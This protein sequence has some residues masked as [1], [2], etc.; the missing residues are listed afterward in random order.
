MLLNQPRKRR[1]RKKSA[2]LSICDF[3]SSLLLGLLCSP[4]S[5]SYFHTHKHTHK[6]APSRNNQTHLPAVLFL[7]LMIIAHFYDAYIYFCRLASRVPEPSLENF[8]IVLLLK[9]L[10]I[11]HLAELHIFSCTSEKKLPAPYV[12]LEKYWL[13][14]LKSL[15][16]TA[17]WRAVK[18][19]LVLTWKIFI[20]VQEMKKHQRKQLKYFGVSIPI[21]VAFCSF[22]ASMV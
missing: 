4:W 15:K 5:R 6:L 19:R 8:Q 22:V 13:V 2:H 20:R 17:S 14:N 10:K 11:V 9:E 12:Q 21:I 7:F 16:K 18:H 3:A 1:R